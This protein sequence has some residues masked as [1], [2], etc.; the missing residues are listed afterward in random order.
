SRFANAER[1]DSTVRPQTTFVGAIFEQGK[2]YADREDENDGA[3]GG[4]RCSPSE[5]GDQALRGPRHHGCAKSH[6]GHNQPQR[7]STPP[8]EPPRDDRAIGN[9]PAG[10]TNSK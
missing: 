9:D 3:Q 8:I 4:K 2:E 6:A 7:K 10:D 5:A 1:S